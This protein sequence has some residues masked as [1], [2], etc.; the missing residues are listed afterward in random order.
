MLMLA[1]VLCAD[2]ARAFPLALSPAE[3][4]EVTVAGSGEPVVLIPGL[5]GSAFGY[6]KLIPLLTDAGYRAI[7]VEPL[8][9]GTSARPEH[10]DYSLTAQ[11]DRI[12]AV[13]DQLGV[14]RAIVIAHSLGAS[15][16]YRMA[17]RR[18]DLVRGIV[19]IDGGPA[20]RAATPAFRRAMELAPWI[21]LF[22]GFN[23]VRRKIHAQLIR[24][25]VDTTWVTDTV[26]DGYTRGAARD[27]DATLKA[28]VTMA[29][30]REPERLRPHLPDIHCPVRLL[31]G[32]ARH[33]GGISE[34]EVTALAE[35]LPAFAVDSIPGVGHFIQE[36]RPEVVL[37][38]VAQVR[39]E[40]L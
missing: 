32:A 37:R 25:S 10:A 30:R 16:A 40:T 35:A 15:M 8:A 6:R 12:A 9:I 38:A 3:S 14:R 2:T 36:E 23:R 26:V 1:L 13:L 31:V 7:V 19:S 21:K 29:Q 33:D 24:E 17:Y 4:V 18:P 28:F 22:G 34:T 39:K 27:F 5:F 11:A 20:E